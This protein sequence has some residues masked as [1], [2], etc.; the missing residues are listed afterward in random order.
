MAGC[1]GYD[2]IAGVYD[3]L[4]ADIDYEGWADF[5]EK[6]FDENGSL[7]APKLWLNPEVKDF[8]EFDNSLDCKDVKLIDYQHMG[9]L[10][11]EI[12]Q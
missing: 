5:F 2:A 12:T 3:R 9:K 1:E 7:P 8:F 6:C 11:F 10:L 4:N